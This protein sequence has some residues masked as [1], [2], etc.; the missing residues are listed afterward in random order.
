MGRWGGGRGNVSGS[1]FYSQISYFTY[2]F[3]SFISYICYRSSGILT[4][5][6]MII[7]WYFMQNF[8]LL[9]IIHQQTHSLMIYSNQV[10]K[11]FLFVSVFCCRFLFFSSSQQMETRLPIGVLCCIQWNSYRHCEQSCQRRG[12]SRPAVCWCFTET[13]VLD[14]AVCWWRRRFGLPMI[15]LHKRS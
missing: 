3:H 1:D 6:F 8:N 7:H 10:L 13:C 9:K 11:W 4:I 14:L 2:L 5:S 15:L 12:R